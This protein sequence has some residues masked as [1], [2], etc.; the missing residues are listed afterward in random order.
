MYILYE[1]NNNAKSYTH[2]EQKEGSL[3]LIKT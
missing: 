2:R 1:K 3:Q